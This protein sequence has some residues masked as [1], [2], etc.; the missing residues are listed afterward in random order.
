MKKFDG[1]NIIPFV[2]IMLVL[3][4]IVLTTSTLVEKRVIPL[5]LPSAHSNT[6]KI[7][8]KSF[9]ITITQKGELFWEEQALNKVEL[10]K[11]VNTIPK[12]SAININCDKNANFDSFILV[13]DALKGAGLTNIAI[14]TKEY[15]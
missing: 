12:E 8:S 5:S 4:A 3:L 6:T 14:V 2:D 1:I 13:L 7:Q 9:T 11:R 15:E 10:K